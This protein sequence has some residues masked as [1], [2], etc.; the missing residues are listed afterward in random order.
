MDQPTVCRRSSCGFGTWGS[1]KQPP[2]AQIHPNLLPEK[3]FAAPWAL[4]WAKLLLSPSTAFLL[5]S[6]SLLQDFP[7][8]LLLSPRHLHDYR[9]CPHHRN[10]AT[11]YCSQSLRFRPP[12]SSLKPLLFFICFSLA[13]RHHLHP[14]LR[15]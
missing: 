13:S 15:L 5:A 6:P 1:V 7:N 3:V 12:P 2:S 11:S 4:S 14:A 10:S 8:I 9:R